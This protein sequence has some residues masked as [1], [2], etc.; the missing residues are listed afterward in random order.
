VAPAPGDDGP[1][2]VPIAAARVDA[3]EGLDI[4]V[5]G[6]P[7]RRDAETAAADPGESIAV[8]LPV[9]AESVRVAIGYRA[10]GA[11]AVRGARGVIV[12]P[13][14]PAGEGTAGRVRIR[15]TWPDG[16]TPMVGPAVEAGDWETSVSATGAFLTG[17]NVSR[18]PVPRV[19]VDLVLDDLSAAEPVWQTNEL[20]ASQLMPAFVS[21]GLFIAVV[22]AGI[23]IMVRLQ[24]PVLV[25]TGGA[26]AARVPADLPDEALAVLCQRRPWQAAAAVLDR[27]IAAGLV[28]GGRLAA[29]RGLRVAAI[30]VG[31]TAAGT[32]AVI[33]PIVGHLGP[34]PYAV[35][36]GML[37]AALMLGLRGRSLPVLTPAGADA[38]MLHSR[39]LQASP[40]P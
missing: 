36:L 21:A 31:T 11:M 20:R 34:W 12:W 4:T 29:G 24:Y 27:L 38:G 25:P 3:V 8:A 16:N 9:G 2:R 30:A 35:P 15:L 6:E 23:L 10:V 5:D 37:A 7:I 13:A 26:D 33:S 19:Y 14:V 18:H 22:G 39:R 32:A 28:D 17:R 1:L 40:E